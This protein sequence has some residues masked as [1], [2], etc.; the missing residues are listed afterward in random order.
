MAGEGKIDAIYLTKNR[1]TPH[2]NAGQMTTINQK[3]KK[4]VR[5]TS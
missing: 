1:G 3:F 2:K 5:F 4:D